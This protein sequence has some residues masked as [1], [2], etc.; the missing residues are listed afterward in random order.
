MQ[1]K[2]ISLG[3]WLSIGD[4]CHGQGEGGPEDMPIPIH[5]GPIRATSGSMCFLSDVG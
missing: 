3:E 5:T 2:P 4:V 1:R